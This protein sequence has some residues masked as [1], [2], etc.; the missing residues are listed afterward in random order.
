MEIQRAF[1]E[2]LLELRKRARLSQAKLA[3]RCGAGVVG[4]RIG[5]LERG[6]GN[7]TLDTIGRLADGL[8]CEAAELFLFDPMAIGESLSLLD[9][10]IVDLWKAADEPTKRKAL[11]ILSELL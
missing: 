7:P 2:R 3:D 9:A 4:Q 1:G 5:E 11:R 6:E 10:R 8:G